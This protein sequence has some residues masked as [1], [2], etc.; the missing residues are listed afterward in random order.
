MK[1]PIFIL[2]LMFSVMLSSSS[3]AKWTKV[4]ESVSG[5]T[6]YVDFERIRKVDGYVYYWV[7]MDYLKPKTSGILSVK[8][9]HQGDCK[10][11]RLMGLSWH[12]YQA[13]MGRGQVYASTN[14]SEWS[15]PLPNSADE[16]ILKEICSLKK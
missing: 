13:P 16:A 9:Y 7:L 3:Y 1:K 6:F 14:G 8:M 2:S 5:N 10:L 4:D 12:F 15:Y 11:F